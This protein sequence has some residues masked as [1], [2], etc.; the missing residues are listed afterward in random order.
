MLLPGQKIWSPL[1]NEKF[2]SFYFRYTALH[3]ACQS[4]QVEALKILLR[5]QA[6][7]TIRNNISSWCPLHEAAWKGHVESCKILLEAGSPLK[8]RT[9]LAETPADLARANREAA[10]RKSMVELCGKL[11]RELLTLN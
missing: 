10:T 4:Y 3:V 1:F 9:N 5:A 6:N 11:C 2:K 8:P 7:P